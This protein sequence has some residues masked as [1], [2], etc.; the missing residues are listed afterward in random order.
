M[1]RKFYIVFETKLAD[2]GHHIVSAVGTKGF[3]SRVLE[4]R[5]NQ[6]AARFVI[7]LQLIVVRRRQ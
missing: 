1:A 7:L 4:F 5:Q 2:A 3:E 6:I